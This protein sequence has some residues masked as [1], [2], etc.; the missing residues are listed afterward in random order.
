[1]HP[2]R[3]V[4]AALADRPE[5]LGAAVISDEG[6]VVESALPPHLDPEAVAALAATALRTLQT[7]GGA[8]GHGQPL[9]TV[10]EAPGGVV[11][12]QRLPTGSTL[13]VLAAPDGDLGALLHDLRRHA[14]ALVELV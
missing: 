5:V 2:L 12:M 1:M 4:L 14:P 9:E 3:T 10:V 11:V 7:L 13:L 6:L 8:T